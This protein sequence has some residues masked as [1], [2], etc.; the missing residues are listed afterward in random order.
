MGG[1]QVFDAQKGNKL[2]QV[3]ADLQFSNLSTAIS[4]D[5]KLAA[6]ADSTGAKHGVI[7][8]VST[9]QQLCKLQTPANQPTHLACFSRDDALLAVLVNQVHVDLYST[10]TGKLVRSIRWEEKFMPPANYS[11]YWGEVGFLADGK[12]LAVSIH[13]TGMIRVFDVASGK[14][15]RQIVVSPNGMAGMTISPDGLTLVAL[16]C[17]ARATRVTG[18]HEKPDESVLVLEA[19]TGK[20][21]GELLVPKINRRWMKIAPDNKTLFANSDRGLGMWNLVTERQTGE[22]T[23]HRSRPY[24]L[25][26]GISPDGKI[27]AY[28][29]QA[30]LHQIDIS[31]DKPAVAING[32]ESP[33]TAAAFS[34]VDSLI[35]TGDFEGKIILW[36]RSTGKCL[37]QLGESAG[38]VRELTFDPRGNLLFAL[39]QRSRFGI[40]IGGNDES[41]LR[42]FNVADGKEA[43][44][45]SYPA[46]NAGPSGGGPRGQNPRICF[47]DGDHWR[48]NSPYGKRTP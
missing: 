22:V 7:F 30:V 40:G 9:G 11:I 42:A 16:P 25:S 21:L 37:C 24:D 15:T 39:F 33:I 4:A 38:A 8:D 35:A 12:S 48:Q 29:D 28:P 44:N 17:V 6:M 23:F 45:T 47:R 5:G 2:L 32:H 43:W 14:E 41:T 34:S 26:Y 13:H 3:A 1:I 10:S 31:T 18:F 46:N 36:E 27:I 20:R 19:A